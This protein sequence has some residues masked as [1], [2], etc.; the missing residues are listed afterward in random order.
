M[1]DVTIKH[2]LE[3]GV[4][5]W[6]AV[7][8]GYQKDHIA[9]M[10]KT[11][12]PTEVAEMW[13]SHAGPSDTAPYGGVR[14]AAGRFYGNLLLELKDLFCGGPKYEEGRHQVAQSATAGRLLLVGVVST[15]VAPY[16][17]AAAIVIGPATAIT[18][19]VIGNAGQTTVCE[20]LESMIRDRNRKQSREARNT[21]EAAF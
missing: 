18:L 15:A 8:P 19:G 3:G 6:V 14:V 12:S 1:N 9:E 10:L 16:V 7:L 20:T 13:L 5:A 21:P 2:L 4:D 17:G 11:A